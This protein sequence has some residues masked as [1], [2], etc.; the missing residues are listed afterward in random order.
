MGGREEPVG[1][2]VILVHRLLKNTVGEKDPASR[3][4][5]ISRSRSASMSGAM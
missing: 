1:R 2:D 4:S 3:K 5:R